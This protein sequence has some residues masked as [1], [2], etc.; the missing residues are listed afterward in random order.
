MP[1][2]YASDAGVALGASA[3]GPV[4]VGSDGAWL[5]V[6]FPRGNTWD[7]QQVGVPATPVIALPVSSDELWSR[8]EDVVAVPVNI[9]IDAE[10]E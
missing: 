9:V 3:E 2:I 10:S 5:F 4:L 7:R 6:E 8:H 1:R